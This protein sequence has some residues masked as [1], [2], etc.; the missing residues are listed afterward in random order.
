MRQNLPGST[1]SHGSAVTSS[2]GNKAETPGSEVLYLALGVVSLTLI[3]CAPVARGQTRH[4]DAPKSQEQKAL[5]SVRALQTPAKARDAFRR[6]AECLAKG[7]AAGSLRHFVRAIHEF[8]DYYEAYSNK[9]AAELLLNRKDE[10]LQSFQKAIDL[11]GGHYARAYF[12][13]GYVLLKQ[14]RPDEAERFVRRGLAEDPSIADGYVVLS[15]ALFNEGRLDEAERNAVEAVR[16]PDP[17]GTKAFLTLA[18]V[19]LKRADYP[20]AVSDLERYLQA[21]RDDHSS[22]GDI[23]SIQKQES[24]QKV[25]GE[26]KAMSTCQRPPG[27]V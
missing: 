15:M 5:V 3:A 22:R 6:G 13:Y 2:Q 4:S 27:C 8:P 18:Y 10:A 17:A 7:D 12:G 11:S 21:V 25:L 19:H 26:L 1:A 23:E 9:G 14:G 24:I 20:S 16:M